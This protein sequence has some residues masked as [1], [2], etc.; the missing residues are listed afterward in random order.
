MKPSLDFYVYAY[1]RDDG[2]PYYIGKGKGNRKNVNHRHVP[3]PQNKERIVVLE[4]NL[5]NLG[6]CALERRY[7]RWYGRKDIRTGILLN[8]TDGGETTLGWVPSENTRKKMREN[9]KG[10]KNPFYGKSHT[11]EHKEKMRR[12]VEQGV[13]S[14]KGRKLSEETKAKMRKN[15]AGEGNPM[16]GV[17]R[18]GDE[19]PFF[20]KTHTEETKKKIG[21]ANSNRIPWN[22]GKPRSEETKEKIRQTKLKNRNKNVYII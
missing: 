10:S 17:K 15:N 1:L 21:L 5:T 4:G 18:T 6:A 11:L 8:L 13:I 7:I 16:F 19:N 2:S 22:K 12:L 14:P 9:N 3:V 20:G